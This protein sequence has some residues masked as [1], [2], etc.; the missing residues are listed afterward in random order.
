MRTLDVGAGVYRMGFP[1][2]LSLDLR[3]ETLPDVQGDARCLPVRSKSVDL[4]YMSHLLEHFTQ[5]EA[6]EILME[7]WRVLKPLAAFYLTVPDLEWGIR[8]LGRGPAAMQVIYGGQNGEWDFHKWGYTKK[9]IVR[10]LE[11][12]G[13]DV[14]S[15][16]PQYYQLNVEGMRRP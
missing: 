4:V 12:Y 6:E 16:R 8:N 1:G 7:V 10:F 3:R 9:T 14:I 11:N 2:L 5:K 13:F 15:V